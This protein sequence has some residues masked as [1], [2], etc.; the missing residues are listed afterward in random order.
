MALPIQGVAAHPDSMQAMVM[1]AFGDRT[2]LA[3]QPWPTPEPGPGQVLIRIHACSVNPIDWRIR[4]GEVKMFVR[5]R[6]PMILGADVSGE[7]A[8]LGPG[9]TRFAIGDLV[10]VKL[11]GDIGGY[12]EYA[13]AAETIVARRPANLTAVEAAAIPACATTALQALRDVAGL[14][15]G[16]RVLV[17]GASG[18][19]GLFAIQLA[20]VLGATVSAVCSPSAAALVTRLG[21]DEVIDYQQTDF[22]RIGQRWNVVFDVSATRSLRQCRRA[23]ERGG[24]YVTTISSMGDLLMPIFNP[25]RSRKGRFVI[26]KSSGADLDYLRGLMEAGTILPVIDRVFPLAQAADAQQYLETGKPRGKVVLT[27]AA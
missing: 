1:T 24:V 27:V 6:P 3:Y 13:V 20:R 19:V 16:Q 14:K 2:V 7:I 8:R 5:T 12:A 18:G 23:M 17:N 21:A 11:P 15:A 10:Y 9:V 4:K 25:L 26:V 22:T